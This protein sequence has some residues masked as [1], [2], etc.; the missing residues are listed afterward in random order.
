MRL[1]KGSN[2][3]SFTME[4]CQIMKEIYSLTDQ[5]AI[6]SIAASHMLST[7]DRFMREDVRILQISGNMRLETLEF[8]DSKHHKN[9]LQSFSHYSS[10][11]NFYQNS[12][13]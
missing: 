10:E 13:N 1:T 2:I 11:N 3:L 4:L 5:L 7:I 8:V 12:T 6:K 9:T